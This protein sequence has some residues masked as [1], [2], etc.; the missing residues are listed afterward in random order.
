MTDDLL[1]ILFWLRTRGPRILVILVGSLLLIR[2]LRVASDRIPRL[3]PAAGGPTITEGEKR[4]RTVASLVRT[5]GTS[6]VL[7]IAG[8]MLFREIGMDIT[9]LLAGADRKSVV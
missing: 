1:E 8:M 6:L 5:V 3:L 4:T 9:P 7:L 2:L